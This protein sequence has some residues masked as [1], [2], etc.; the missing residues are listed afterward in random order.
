MKA[1]QELQHYLLNTY[2]EPE[3]CDSQWREIYVQL[4]RQPDRTLDGPNFTRI[5]ARDLWHLFSFYDEGFFR[6]HLRQSLN[7]AT[8]TFR[9]SRRMTN[10]AGLTTMVVHRGEAVPRQFEIALS[11]KLLFDAFRDGTAIEYV[12][13]LACRDRLA[14][15]MRVFEHELVHLA[16]LLAWNESQCRRERFQRI[17]RQLFGHTDYRHQLVPSS[18]KEARRTGLALGARVCFEYRGQCLV[19]FINRIRHRA[20]VL[21]EDPAGQRYS[22]GKRYRKFYVPLPLLKPAE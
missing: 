12:N 15:L 13:G 17:A 7:G 9:F 3:R 19:G 20:T 11:S 21:V 18:F 14:A 1:I 2:L 8:L 5:S 4:L 10:S 22:D 16:E 6:G